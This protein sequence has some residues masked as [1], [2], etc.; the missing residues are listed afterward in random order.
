MKKILFCIILSTAIVQTHAQDYFSLR[1][2]IYIDEEL[3]FEGDSINH[4]I[5]MMN[6]FPMTDMR[7]ILVELALDSTYLSH[8]ELPFSLFLCCIASNDT[9]PLNFCDTIILEDSLAIFHAYCPIQEK[10]I[11]GGRE[12]ILKDLVHDFSNIKGVMEKSFKFL[13]FDKNKRT[14][15]SLCSSSIDVVSPRQSFIKKQEFRKCFCP[16]DRNSIHYLLE[17]MQW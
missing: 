15:S 13:Y 5:S 4:T 14:Y 6:T 2:V 3:E 12:L 11:P 1:K 7:F 17:E 16:I 9:I 8:S 10:D